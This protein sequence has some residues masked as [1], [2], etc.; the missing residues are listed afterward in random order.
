VRRCKCKC[1]WCGWAHGADKGQKVSSSRWRCTMR[2]ACAILQQGGGVLQ[3]VKAR[4]NGARGENGDHSERNVVGSSAV[5][6]KKVFF[7][8]EGKGREDKGPAQAHMHT[9]AHGPILLHMH[10]HMHTHTRSYAH[11]HTRTPQKNK[12][13]K[14]E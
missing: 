7:Y 2:R 4:V 8:A 3:V 13:I 14:K 11:E 1:E 10:M 5:E 12:K 6:L 9:H